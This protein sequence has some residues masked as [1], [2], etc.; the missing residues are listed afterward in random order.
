MI[1]GDDADSTIDDATIDALLEREAALAEGRSPRNL[2]VGSEFDGLA[3]TLDLLDAVWPTAVNPRAL[4]AEGSRLGP[5][6]LFEERGRGGCGVVYRA[7]DNRMGR[8]VALKVLRD[9]LEGQE[10]ANLL[11]E[12]LAGRLDHPNIIQVHE[13]GI[14]ADRAYIASAYCP[15]PSLQEWLESRE[16]PVP[17][18]EAARIVM[19]LARAV[20]H[21]HS[22][23]VL[24]R[25]L[26]PG[27][28]L[29]WPEPS[30]GLDFTLRL[31]DFGLA[32][33][34]EGFQNPDDPLG[35][36][37]TIAF[38]ALGSPPYMSPEQAEGRPG[39]IGFASDIYGLGGI[40]YALLTRR[41]PH[42]GESRDETLELAR[43][44]DVIP[45]ARFRARLPRD[46][47]TIAMTCL[48][49]EPGR[50]YG[51][52]EAVAADLERFSNGEPIKARR[53][54]VVV[55]AMLQARRHPWRAVSAVL[56]TILVIGGLAGVWLYTV[57]LRAAN[58]LFARSLYNGR[59]REAQTALDENRVENAQAILE[60]L[61]RID[62]ENE[63][64]FSERLLRRRAYDALHTF[65]VET[66]NAATI[67]L[68]GTRVTLIDDDGR[69]E[70]IDVDPRSRGSTGIASATLGIW[71]RSD[72]IDMFNHG[73][74]FHL[75]GQRLLISESPAGDMHRTFAVRLI[76][77]S[78][79]VESARWQ[80]VDGLEKGYPR[81][82]VAGEVLAIIGYD[83][84]HK[85]AAVHLFRVRSPSE[86]HFSEF[87]GVGVVATRDSDRLLV[88]DHDRS[89]LVDAATGTVVRTLPGKGH[90]GLHPVYSAMNRAGS[91]LAGIDSD[92]SL[93]IHDL[94][95]DD[96]PIIDRI[97]AETVGIPMSLEFANDSLVL[98]TETTRVQG[99][100]VIL[101]RLRHPHTGRLRTIPQ[102]NAELREPNVAISLDG[103]RIAI[104]GGAHEH[105]LL[106]TIVDSA[107]G[108]VVAKFP[109]NSRGI[110]QIAFQ[111][112][113]EALL[114]QPIGS[115][116][117]TLWSFERRAAVPPD[118]VAHRAEGW[119]LAWSP[120]GRILAS[121]A[122]GDQDERAL[123]FWDARS[124]SLIR[125]V[126]GHLSTVAAL[127]YS[128]D[129]R[130]VVT[131][132]LRTSRNLLLWDVKSGEFLGI[133]PG[134]KGKARAV[135]WSPD[136]RTIAAAGDDGVVRLWD[137]S[138][139]TLRA[140]LSGHRDLI[141]GLA[142]RHDGG[143]LASASSDTT[144]RLWDPFTGR[145]IATLPAEEPLLG[146]SFRPDGRQLAA[147]GNQGGLYTWNGHPQEG[148]RP[149]TVLKLEEEE[150]RAVA[151]SPDSRELAIAG[152]GRTIHIW[153]SQLHQEILKL[154]GH[155]ELIH[156][157]AFSPDGETLASIDHSGVIRFWDSETRV[158]DS[159][160]PGIAARRG[161]PNRAER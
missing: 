146:L 38:S 86:P 9:G 105:W 124:R 7:L 132:T 156:G 95:R 149:S 42:M 116:R 150:L 94:E 40:L 108:E 43:K 131:G 134:M 64:S 98:R 118:R 45:P 31:S 110:H 82:L 151:Y 129:G 28:V 14:D 8:I 104:A 29:L 75:G 26:K 106:P 48:A 39:G 115:R 74:A 160:P 65:P 17:P 35:V 155:Q 83:W 99:R 67:H 102:P 11:R 79:A 15:G 145:S 135:A 119:A 56:A 85:N 33:L 89:R 62:G 121:T 32:R 18:R 36:L 158:D 107:T 154:K 138:S 130:M 72:L 161:E 63:A 57:R 100:P 152:K 30:D 22:R 54:P 153:D 34:I 123:R 88:L 66:R 51:S 112:D 92:G 27:N 1:D 69:I 90:F 6:T 3:R 41:P 143:T 122:D 71:G 125:G 55:R 139:K 12:A 58:A 70:S 117:L 59:L 68:A 101:T 2:P 78:D 136:G 148:D 109:G 44:G 20:A 87:R 144:I 53:T 128:P 157:L 97:P 76:D 50:R 84:N 141:F 47:E 93:V 13:V 81:L 127:A 24:H 10:R 137:V 80:R 19:V 4:G 37:R 142:F 103:R 25:D 91:K 60:Q 147:I 21:A 159:S 46:L 120:D 49:R 61:P 96:A 133:L 5:F 113:G 77:G 52:A 16:S 111:D 23:G 140:E 126:F 114:I 73:F